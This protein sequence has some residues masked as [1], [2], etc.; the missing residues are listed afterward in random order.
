MILKLLRYLLVDRKASQSS[1]AEHAHKMEQDGQSLLQK[2]ENVTDND[3]HQR[4]ITH[5][6]GIERWGQ[7]R[8]KAFLG[9]PYEMDEYDQYRPEKGL[10]VAQLREAF[11]TTREETV[12]I[13]RLMSEAQTLGAEEVPHNQYGPLKAKSW[14]YYLNFHANVESLRLRK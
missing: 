10:S 3:V 7:Q 11:A 9:H 12:K 4:V 6:I 8:L 2:Y 1:L 14:L 13:A 5:I